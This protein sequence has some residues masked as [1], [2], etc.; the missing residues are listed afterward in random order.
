MQG[1]VN[2]DK[3]SARW[4]GKLKSPGSG[5]FEV[6]VKADNGVKLFIDGNLVINSWT[7]QAPGQFKT[8]YYEFEEGKLYDIKIEFYENI[9]TCRVRLGLAPVEGGNELQDA[10]DVAKDADVVVLNLGMAKNYEGEQRD[11]DY[12]ELPPMQIELLNEVLKVNKNVVVVLNNGSAMLMNEWNNKVPAIVEALYP[13]EQ[14]GDALA[15]ILFGEV[16]PSGKLPFT[17][18]QKWEDHPAAKTYPGEREIAHYSEGIFMGYR[19]FDKYDIDPLY[20]FGYGLSYTTFEYSNLELSS[21][22]IEKNDTFEISLSVTNIG[23]MDGDEIIQLYIHDNEASVEREEKSL[24][25]FSR[26][27]LKV[28]ESKPVTFKIDK[29]S[30]SFYD[31]D[32][33]EWIVEPG[34]FEILIG[35]SSKDIRLKETFEYKN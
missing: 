10:I 25:G 35:A 7:D 1:V 15:Q 13:G 30:L 17:I 34:R 19:H 20:E 14:G 31:V 21:K 32:K 29:S 24:K 8:D 33:K 26:V 11:R 12:L 22:T 27:S 6:G 4:T 16:N 2:D 18:M 28:G 9:G 5:Q 3:F 23:K